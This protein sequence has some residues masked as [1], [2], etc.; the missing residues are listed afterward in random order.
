MTRR[1]AHDPLSHG[2][3]EDARKWAPREM[4]MVSDYL[5]QFFPSAYTL[6]RV[7]LGSIPPSET[8]EV[9]EEHE[10]VEGKLIPTGKKRITAGVRH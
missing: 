4:Q 10:V 3:T 1:I 5:A 6:T 9:L 7:K 8:G 2:D